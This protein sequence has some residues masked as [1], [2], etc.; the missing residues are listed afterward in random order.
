MGAGCELTA[1]IL[2]N[3]G[4]W[5]W[6]LITALDSVLFIYMQGD[7]TAPEHLQEA[8]LALAPPPVF[9]PPCHL[10]RCVARSRPPRFVL[11]R[12]VARSRSASISLRSL[13][14]FE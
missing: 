1:R 8:I 4:R 3:T 13:F 7:C 12:G 11:L 6:S 5:V 10:L 9:R 14:C 2:P